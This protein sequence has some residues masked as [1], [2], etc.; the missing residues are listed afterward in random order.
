MFNDGELRCLVK[1]L[2]V[3]RLLVRIGSLGSE[4]EMFSR[5]WRSLGIRCTMHQCGDV[6]ME[7]AISSYVF[8]DCY[9]NYQ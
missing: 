7:T 2:S 6:V 8:R 1:R 9:S 3:S 4:I 5:G